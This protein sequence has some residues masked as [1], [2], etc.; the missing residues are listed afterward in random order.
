MWRHQQL[1]RAAQTIST[2]QCRADAGPRARLD[3]GRQNRISPIRGGRGRGTGGGAAIARNQT[4]RK[5]ETPTAAKQ[6]TH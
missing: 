1:S 6:G 5:R 2:Q 3:A 4:V